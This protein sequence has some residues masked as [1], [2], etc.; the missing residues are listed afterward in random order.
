MAYVFSQVVITAVS[1]IFRPV[2]TASG[3]RDLVSG[4]PDAEYARYPALSREAILEAV[5]AFLEELPS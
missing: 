1:G 4:I 2:K 5:D 3:F